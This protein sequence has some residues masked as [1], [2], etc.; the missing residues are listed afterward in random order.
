MLAQLNS[1]KLVTI[2]LT[3]SFHIRSQVLYFCLLMLHDMPIFSVSISGT[4]WLPT[5]SALRQVVNKFLAL[6]V[7][8][9]GL[10]LLCL[11]INDYQIH[12]FPRIQKYNMSQSC[13]GIVCSISCNLNVQQPHNE[14]NFERY[15]MKCFTFHFWFRNFYFLHL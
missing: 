7:I 13:R 10:S 8:F 15:E 4:L 1:P 9:A 11:S 14:L 2:S 12:G 6:A 5:V 3:P